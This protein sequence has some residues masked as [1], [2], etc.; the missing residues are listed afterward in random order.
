VG[1]FYP[2]PSAGI[3]TFNDTKNLKTIEICDIFGQLILS[4]GNKKQIDLSGFAKGIYFAKINGEKV[5]K[6]VKE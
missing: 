5:L 3:F 6:L 1:L 2:N 4:Q